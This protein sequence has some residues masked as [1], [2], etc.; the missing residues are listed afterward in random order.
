M[1]KNVLFHTK[2]VF[3][4]TDHLPI[5]TV[6]VYKRWEGVPQ[7]CNAYWGNSTNVLEEIGRI[8]EG[9]YFPFLA[10]LKVKGNL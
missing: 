1:P 4:E 7:A 6:T 3:R 2:A 9:L 8:G 5:Q 10:A